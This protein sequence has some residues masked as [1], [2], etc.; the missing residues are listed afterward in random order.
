MSQYR[1]RQLDLYF[2][3][4]VCLDI[5]DMN[6]KVTIALLILGALLVIAVAQRLP[7]HTPL[8]VAV[9][10]LADT[11][12][13]ALQQQLSRLERQHTATVRRLSELEQYF[14]STKLGLAQP[15][16]LELEN[17]EQ[18]EVEG[19]EP[20]AS[21]PPTPTPGDS[22]VA[23]IEES[24]LTVEEFESIQQ[25]AYAAYLAGFEEQWSL[26]R[27]RYL[28]QDRAPSVAERL[29][30]EL[31]DD[32]Y[33]RYLFAS[34]SSNRVRVRQVMQGSAAEQ[35]GLSNGDIVISY[36]N[37][38]VFTFSDLRR[39]SYEGQLGESVVL[40]VRGTDGNV[41][42]LLMPRG[43]LGLTGYGGWREAPDT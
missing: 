5:F 9:S 15:L 42:Q 26:R 17:T 7:F 11:E 14:A 39:L 25:R 6:L 36:A 23:R 13:D 16:A 1:A 40:E 33:D 4:G 31:G 41:S 18:T 19:T 12:I 34:G 35:A 29:R 3:R 20:V 30:G 37:E 43:P 8:P 38:R 22:N 32:S 10:P 27:Q 21:P 2:P 24:G 28:E